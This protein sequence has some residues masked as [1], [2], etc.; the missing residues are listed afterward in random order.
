MEKHCVPCGVLAGG[1]GFR[2]ADVLL[3]ARG[4][5][6]R[7]EEGRQSV[8]AVGGRYNRVRMRLKKL[9][10]PF[11]LLFLTWCLPLLAQDDS[12]DWHNNYKEALEEA[13][14]THKPIFLEYRCEP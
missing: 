4:A 1:T 10:I 9:V 14:R 11:S 7:M 12:L 3:T 8:P 6:G 13:K 5:H 2:A